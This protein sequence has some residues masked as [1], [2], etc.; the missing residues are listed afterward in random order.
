MKIMHKNIKYMLKTSSDSG[1]IPSYRKSCS[2]TW[3]WNQF[4]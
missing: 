2:W 1:N 4:L 3:W